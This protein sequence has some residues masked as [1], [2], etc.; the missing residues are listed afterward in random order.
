MHGPTGHLAPQRT[1]RIEIVEELL[2]Y[3]AAIPEAHLVQSSRN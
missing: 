1:K 3:E 2:V